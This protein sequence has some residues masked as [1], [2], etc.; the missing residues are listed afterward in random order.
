MT[1]ECGPFLTLMLYCW[2]SD[3]SKTYYGC[4]PLVRLCSLSLSLSL[5]VPQITEEP[6]S[7]EDAILGEPAQFVVKANGSHLT[8]T[9]Y[10][11]TTKQLLPNEKRVSV[12]NTQILQINKV[13]LSDEGYYVCTI[14]NPTGGS[15]ET[16]PARLTTSMEP[17]VL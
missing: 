16:K 10:R 2:N 12:G 17:Y 9:W 5:S 11:Q 4:I 15:V 3:R 13:E 8:Y 6:H 7:L 14:C 1:F